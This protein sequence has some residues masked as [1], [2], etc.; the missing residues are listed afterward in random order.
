MGNKIVYKQYI[1]KTKEEPEA[2]VYKVSN[3]KRCPLSVRR[4]KRIRLMRDTK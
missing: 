3:Y 4:V 1:R 2:K